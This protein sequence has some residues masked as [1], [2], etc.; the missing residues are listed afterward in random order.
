M[1]DKL[2]FR[3]KVVSKL[4]IA[5]SLFRSLD[6]ESDVRP[7]GISFLVVIKNCESWIERSLFSVLSVADEVIVVDSSSDSTPLIV[8]RLAEEHTKIRYFYYNPVYDSGSWKCFVDC[9]N[10]GLNKTRFRWVFKWDGDMVGDGLEVW[11]DR[12]KSLNSNRFYCVDVGRI[13]AGLDLEFGSFEGR[14]FTYSKRVKYR[15]VFDRDSIVFPVWFRLL[16][17]HERFILHLNP[18]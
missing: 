15:W 5:G 3:D 11:L 1:L 10:F 12:L 7:F 8:K 6:G 18:K 17:W 14:L 9:L 13:N 16:R 2:T 4:H